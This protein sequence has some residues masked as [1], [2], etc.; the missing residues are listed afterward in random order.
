MNKISKYMIISF[1]VLIV[2]ITA[3]ALDREVKI[4]GTAVIDSE[5]IDSKIPDELISQSII[6]KG[7]TAIQQE[8]EA[9]IREEYLAEHSRI[10]N[11]ND[12]K[13]IAEATIVLK[14]VKS[15]IKD[16]GIDVNSE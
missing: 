8:S 10:Y 7:V 14:T 11:S 9:K 1:F 5:L 2:A 12:L 16:G 6:D 15:E 13:L 4:T 3:I